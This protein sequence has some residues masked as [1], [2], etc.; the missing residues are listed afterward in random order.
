M[1]TRGGSVGAVIIAVRA[2]L[3]G[4]MEQKRTHTTME[5]SRGRPTPTALWE[6]A[7]TSCPRS[8]GLP[9]KKIQLPGP[10]V[11]R[12]VLALALPG[13]T[14]GAK[15]PVLTLQAAAAKREGPEQQAEKWPWAPTRPAPAGGVT[16]Q[17]PHRRGPRR[18]GS[19][20][21]GGENGSHGKC[22]QRSQ[23]SATPATWV[24]RPS[25]G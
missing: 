17:D 4:S 21:A 12:T 2:G 3:G 20:Q 6:K 24:N 18:R 13:D 14:P 1:E 10:E 5:R 8:P 22:F 7:G 15:D 9:P 16:P 23:N 19:T 11:T 25:S